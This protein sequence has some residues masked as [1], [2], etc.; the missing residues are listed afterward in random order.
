[1][2]RTATAPKSTTAWFQDYVFIEVTKG[3]E[4]ETPQRKLRVEPNQR[5]LSLTVARFADL[6]A[7]N[8]AAAEISS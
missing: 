8:R 6:R 7:S 1:L 5:E 2:R 4:Y 3:F